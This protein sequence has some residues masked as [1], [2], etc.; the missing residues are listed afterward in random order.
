MEYQ[1]IVLSKEGHITRITL[2]R[3]EAGNAID[4]TMAQELEAACLSV[5]QDDE[6]YVVIITGAG[7]GVFCTGG[8]P[9]GGAA[10]AV[11]GIDRPVL[12][13]I[14]GDTIGEGLELALAGDIRVAS[15]QARFGLPQI[16]RGLIPTDGGTQRLPRIV[17]RSR[18]LE[19]LLTGET[20][21]A[22]RALE[23][24]LVNKVCEPKL[25]LDD[26]SAIAGMMADKAPV[27]LRYAKEAILKGLD[28]TLDEGLRLEA[29]LYLLLHTT[30]DR[31]EGIRAFLEK[32]PPRFQGR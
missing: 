5:N 13:A 15:D 30:A 9:G 2:N 17:G 12:V 10:A 24:G 19:L 25:L 3:P 31:T 32:R 27:A 4:L 20:I 11:A 28:L 22:A 18:A 16:S 8:E 1:T 14:N 6:T 26:V 23:I 21:D 29:D 7:D